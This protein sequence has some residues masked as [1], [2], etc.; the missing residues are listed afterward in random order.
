MGVGGGRWNHLVATCEH[1]VPMKRFSLTAI[2][3]SIYP[4][5]VILQHII[6][7]DVGQEWN[8]NE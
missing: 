3:L 8:K 4:T 2:D 5:S 6:I 1:A 7:K